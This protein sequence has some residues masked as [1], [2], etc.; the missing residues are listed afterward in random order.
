VASFSY[1]K[2]NKEKAIEWGDVTLYDYLL[3]PKKYIP[4]EQPQ[5][6]AAEPGSRCRPGCTTLGA[7]VAARQPCGAGPCSQASTLSVV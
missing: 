4:G 6:A 5:P 7:R 3:N 2:A 1:S